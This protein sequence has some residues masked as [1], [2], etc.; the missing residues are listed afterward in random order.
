M[1]DIE[2]GVLDSTTDSTQDVALLEQEEQEVSSRPDWEESRKEEPKEEPKEED[3]QRTDEGHKEEEQASDQDKVSPPYDRPTM[4]QLREEFPDLF[5]KFPSMRDIYYR[6]QEFSQIF[7]T[8]E[9]AREASANSQSFND[10]SDKVLSGD[11]DTLFGAIK[12]ADERAFDK[13]AE[14]ILPTLYKLSPDAH[15]KA[16]LPLMQNLVRGFYLEGKKRNDEN[17][18]N[19]AEY[20]SDFIFGD[21]AIA[22]GEKTMLPPKQEPTQEQKDFQAEK[23]K[24]NN[25]RYSSFVNSVRGTAANDL[26]S[27]VDVKSKIDPEG[28]F[29]DFI[30]E[31][32]V[33]KVLQEVDKQLVADKAHMKY[34]NSLWDKANREGFNDAWKSRILSAYL[35]RAKSLVPTLRAKYVSEALG[36]GVKAS[37][38]AKEL[39]E[40]NN[41]RREPGTGGRTSR[42]NNGPVDAKRVDWDKTSDLDL[43]N[44]NITYRR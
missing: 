16:T 20:L 1:P 15:Y 42:E 21:T 23:A 22:K 40:R 35:A 2:E 30:R 28:V 19:S 4:Q 12:A 17:V 18:M 10:L 44:D 41:S 6:E 25:E 13:V 26:R 37:G 38:K 5:K 34:M 31:T 27:I 8:V 36:S 14:N 32:I 33:G 7:S 29:T 39:A 24:F 43:L 3:Q 11:G 9:D